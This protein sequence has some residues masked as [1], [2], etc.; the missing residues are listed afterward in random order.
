MVKTLASP[1]GMTGIFLI[2]IGLVMAVVGIILLIANQNSPKPWYIWFL[3]I[4]GA[5]LG[6][7]GGI[8]LAVWFSSYEDKN[9][10]N[11]NLK[12]PEYRMESSFEKVNLQTNPNIPINVAKIDAPQNN[13]VNVESQQDTD[14]LDL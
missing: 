11:Q 12:C 2:I 6:I 10:D 8:I 7:I 5:V 9:C 14:D 4:S 3:L 13:I 1:I